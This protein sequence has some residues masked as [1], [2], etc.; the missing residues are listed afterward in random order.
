MSDDKPGSPPLPGSGEHPFKSEIRKRLE[1]F[2]E[3][4]M[5]VMARA[6]ERLTQAASGA[7]YQAVKAPPLSGGWVIT[8]RGSGPHH[9][10]D[11]KDANRLASL[12]VAELRACGH[13]VASASFDNGS[14]EDVMIPSTPPARTP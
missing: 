3:N 4:T 2:D 5:P 10:H 7:A 14:K 8:I 6:V 12:F 13:A 9:N 11:E 1:S